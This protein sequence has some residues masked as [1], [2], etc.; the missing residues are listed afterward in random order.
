MLSEFRVSFISV[1][2]KLFKICGLRVK[3]GEFLCFIVVVSALMRVQT[4][5]AILVREWMM[6]NSLS[7]IQCESFIILR[8]S[9]PACSMINTFKNRIDNSLGK[10]V[11]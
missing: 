3:A 7:A 8:V 2:Q 1:I 4:I 6:S 10:V 5:D 9:D 11:G